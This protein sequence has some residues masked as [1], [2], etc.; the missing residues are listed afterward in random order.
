MKHVLAAAVL[1]AFFIGSP[2]Q[3]ATSCAS[4]EKVISDIR[5]QVP[6][7]DILTIQG[8]GVQVVKDI[9]GRLTG[10]TDFAEDM[11]LLFTKDGATGGLLVGF[12][13]SCATGSGSLPEVAV[14]MI[15]GASA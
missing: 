4:P 5:L 7:S 9:L 6:D 2:A 13:N 15:K 14:R 11:F 12:T 1:A 8:E 3:A 10:R